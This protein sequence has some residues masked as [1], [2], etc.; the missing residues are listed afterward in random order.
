[1]LREAKRLSADAQRLSQSGHGESNGAYL[2]ELLALEILLKCCVL[3]ETR[4]L[5]RGHDYVNIFLR[6]SASARQA[7]ITSAA[8]RMGPS[9]N[10]SDPYWLLKLFSSNFIRTRYPYE[11]YRPGLTEA[12]YERIGAE[13]LE[14]GGK[15]EEATFDFR[16][17]ELFG[18]LFALTE[19]AD[20]RIDA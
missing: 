11:A 5:E 12:E 10:F 13:W 17:N 18:F 8:N 1:M 16:P 20:A 3:L 19:F 2:L 4:S 14:A 9:A 15:V 7:I 6:L